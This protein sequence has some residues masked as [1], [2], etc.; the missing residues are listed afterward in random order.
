MNTNSG[1][2]PSAAA[3]STYAVHAPS[4]H[5]RPGGSRSASEQGE[6]VLEDPG[7]LGG[8]AVQT[9]VCSHPTSSVAR[10]VFGV[11]SMMARSMLRDLV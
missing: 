11:Y 3:D 6:D 7:A 1:R 2:F 4:S 9:L 8:V 10:T 5:T